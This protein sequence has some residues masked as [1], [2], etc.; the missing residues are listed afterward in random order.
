MLKRSEFIEIFFASNGFF[1]FHIYLK[2]IVILKSLPIDSVSK[3]ILQANFL[4]E[5]GALQMP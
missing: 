1:F 2:E 4:R 3:I 5:G